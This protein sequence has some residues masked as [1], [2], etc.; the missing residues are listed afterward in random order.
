MFGVIADHGPLATAAPVFR[1]F[2]ANET[3]T[4]YD[5]IRDTCLSKTLLE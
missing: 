4:F 2:L 3:D 5:G 1:G